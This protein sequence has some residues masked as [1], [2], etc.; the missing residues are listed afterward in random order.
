MKR[1]LPAIIAIVLVLL[2]T[3][4]A[5]DKPVAKNNDAIAP[6]LT[7]EEVKTLVFSHA[8]V[9]EA[10]VTDLDVE[11]DMENGKVVYDISFD[12]G[13]YEYDYDIDAYTGKILRNEKEKVD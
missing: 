3:G 9:D 7:K 12:A 4:C 11:L 8:K 13:G 10:V 5:A 2:L 6:M 1:K